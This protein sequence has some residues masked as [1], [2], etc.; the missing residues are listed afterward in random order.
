MYNILESMEYKNHKIILTHSEDLEEYMNPR[1]W[2]KLTKMYCHHK[3]YTLG[4]EIINDSLD[5]RDFN[6]WDEVSKELQKLQD[7]AII[8]PLSMY[9]H[10]GITI[11]LGTGGCKFDSGQ[12]GFVFI[13]KDDLRKEY[14]C[15]RITKKI[16]EKAHKVLQMEVKNYDFYVRGEVYSC[17]VMDPE[18]EFVED[19]SETTL[20][21][22]NCKQMFINAKRHLDE[23]LP[24]ELELLIA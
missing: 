23:S 12:L 13:T 15:K 16:L 6:S 22:D 21:Y 19:I 14:G 2:H 11:Y 1:N 5:I 3:N 20:G 9:E 17:E 8:E 24:P 4:D 18:G 7:I 10:S